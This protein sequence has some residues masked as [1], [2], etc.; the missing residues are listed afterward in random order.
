MNQLR[1]NYESTDESIRTSNSL[2]NLYSFFIDII[3]LLP[4]FTILVDYM[5]SNQDPLTQLA[6]WGWAYRTRSTTPPAAGPN[7]RGLWAW[8]IDGSL[9]V[10]D[11]I[12]GVQ[13]GGFFC[14]GLNGIRMGFWMCFFLMGFLQHLKIGGWMGFEW[15]V[16]LNG[17]SI[18]WYLNGDFKLGCSWT[19]GTEWF[20][21]TS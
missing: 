13:N 19:Y 18:C 9:A 14:A 3:L 5:I 8:S 7:L 2:I 11:T 10:G 16:F 15:D 20:D 21:S 1:I 17:I 12:C 6:T 4:L